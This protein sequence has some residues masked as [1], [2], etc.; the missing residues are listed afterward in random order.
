MQT[1]A[2][3]NVKDADS[4]FESLLVQLENELSGQYVVTR[5]LPPVARENER[6][7]TMIVE[8]EGVSRPACH[9]AYIKDENKMLFDYPFAMLPDYVYAPSICLRW[10]GLD[11]DEGRVRAALTGSGVLLVALGWWLAE[12]NMDFAGELLCG[13]LAVFGIVIAAS[14]IASLLGMSKF[15]GAETASRVITEFAKRKKLQIID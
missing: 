5:R 7:V 13:I 12:T 15:S 10:F 1:I 14:F 11:I 8:R 2:L 4:L 9:L 3:G 6:E